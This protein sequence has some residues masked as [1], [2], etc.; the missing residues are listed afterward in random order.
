LQDCSRLGLIALC[1]LVRRRYKLFDL[2]NIDCSALLKQTFEKF[3][4]KVLKK[5]RAELQRGYQLPDQIFQR[6]RKIGVTKNSTNSGGCETPAE[7][8]A[9]NGRRTVCPRI[10]KLNFVRN[11]RRPK[12]HLYLKSINRCVPG[13]RRAIIYPLAREYFAITI[14]INTRSDQI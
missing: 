13:D 7:P 5:F 9:S 2:R 4:L 14:R 6:A 1:T 11:S 8:V 3:D 10:H 12:R